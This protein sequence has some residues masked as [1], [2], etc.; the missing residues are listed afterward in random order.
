VLLLDTSV[1]IEV[2]RGREAARR[3]DELRETQPPPLIC[4]IN[5]YEVWRGA[6]TPEEDS[7]RRLLSALRTVPLTAREGE[8]AGIWR[9]DF[10]S[11]GVALSQSDCLVAAAAVSAGARL[12][13][14]NPKDF[15]MPGLEVEPWPTGA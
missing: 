10:A 2:L 1:L 15:P 3:L 4:A 12:A 14:G 11:R 5:V 8:M 7:I 9:R 6:R 13:T